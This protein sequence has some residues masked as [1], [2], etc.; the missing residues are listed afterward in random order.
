MALNEE[1]LNSV[2]RVAASEMRSSFPTETAA[3]TG[4]MAGVS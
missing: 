1:P 4:P 3:P 2:L